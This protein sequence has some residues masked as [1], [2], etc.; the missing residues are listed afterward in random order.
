MTALAKRNPISVLNVRRK[1]EA[2]TIRAVVAY[3]V[4]SPVL[5]L[6]GV[7]LIASAALLIFLISRRWPDNAET[8]LVF[9][10]WVIAAFAQASSVFY[11]WSLSSDTVTTLVRQLLA[12]H[13]IGW[14]LVGILLMAGQAWQLSQ[15]RVVRSLMVF[16][17]Y[18][19]I[20]SIV[21]LAIAAI[22]SMGSFSLPTPMRILLGEGSDRYTAAHM[23]IR[24]NSFG[25]KL[26]RLTVFFPYPTA[27][28]LS[29]IAMF[30]IALCERNPWWRSVGLAAGL[31]GVVLSYSRA[32]IVILP[33]AFLVFCV[34]RGKV[35]RWMP[36]ALSVGGLVAIGSLLVGL[37]PIDALTELTG[38]FFEARSGSSAARAI[39]NQ[40]NW[41][42][43]LDSPVF[44]HGWCCT[45]SVHPKEYLPI[46]THSA[47]YGTLYTGGV[48]TF[49][50]LVLAVLVTS[51]SVLREAL[52]GRDDA[53]ASLAMLLALT[54][55]GYGESLF[56]LVLPCMFIFLFI[57]SSLPGEKQIH[58][59]LSQVG[60]A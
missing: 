19:I 12:F 10:V 59:S 27:L 45:V 6:L 14:L 51:I 50:S 7:Q 34:L 37:N 52:Q 30:L 24:E 57:G 21:A 25:Q 35:A 3:F 60:K 33:L 15:E 29:G 48:L 16:G 2:D 54:L 13:I 31:C 42:E 56:D 22:G 23:F 41:Q 32:A 46:G 1:E 38:A 28:G 47:F 9:T 55:Y 43:F 53:A 20:M 49:G 8:N 4:L 11:N 17:L 5:W 58:S 44:G 26:P 18:I 40:T 36:I 39:L